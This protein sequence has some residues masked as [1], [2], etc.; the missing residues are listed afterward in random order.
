MTD[1]Y[2]PEGIPEEWSDI[3]DHWLEL[4]YLEFMYG[5]DR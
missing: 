1:D 5:G 2:R 3:D 4:E